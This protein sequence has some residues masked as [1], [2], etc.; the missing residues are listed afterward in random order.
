MEWND[1]EDS[2]SSLMRKLRESNVDGF[3]P[4]LEDQ[5][6][7]TEKKDVDLPDYLFGQRDW[8]PGDYVREKATIQF[9][10]IPV[11]RPAE[12][13]TPVSPAPITKEQFIAKQ[14]TPAS[15]IPEG[16]NLMEMMR[17]YQ[18]MIQN[19]QGAQIDTGLLTG[20]MRA[21][22]TIGAALGTPGKPVD[23]SGVESISARGVIPMQG[24][25]A[26]QASAM[27]FLKMMQSEKE[28]KERLEAQKL[29]KEQAAEFKQE[30]LKDKLLMK[31]NELF[32]APYKAR[33]GALGMSATVINRA[34]AL[35]AL[36]A[37]NDIKGTIQERELASMLDNMLRQGGT[38]VKTIDELV[39]KDWKHSGMK[40]VE[41]MTNEPQSRE[42]N[43]LLSIVRGMTERERGVAEANIKDF[44]ARIA[45]SAPEA[46][47]RDPVFQSKLDTT[48]ITEL[49]TKKRKGETT[50]TFAAQK[51]KSFQDTGRKASP[52]KV[53][54]KNPQGQVGEI[55]ESQLEKALKQGY[56][57]V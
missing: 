54:V 13:T 12:Q 4:R 19:A 32:E 47:W 42:R 8:T 31:Y 50:E 20:L 49:A 45:S 26:S 24:V 43:K 41:W 29:A 1:Q 11:E 56:T 5:E 17:R 14:R 7:S 22:N 57:K 40:I 33:S 48:G 53:L 6:Y 34:N 35:D 28:L 15:S 3:D 23:Q 37:G 55:P 18:Q 16:A 51:L 38:S 30:G 25:K 21:G 27:E 46:L 52:G 10:P 2:Y 39:P 9:P 44:Q 36:I